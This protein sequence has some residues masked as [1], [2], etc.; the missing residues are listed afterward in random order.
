MQS[1]MTMGA[2]RAG[3]LAI[4][5]LSTTTASAQAT[6]ISFVHAGVGAG[7]LDG[8][9]FSLRDFKIT[10]V[11]DTDDRVPF[12]GSLK[13]PHQA[14]SILIAGLGTFDI[15]T[16]THTSVS[17]SSSTVEYA[18][19]IEGGSALIAGPS[20]PAF[21]TWNMLDAVGPVSGSALLLQWGD[22]FAPIQTSGGVLF[23]EV[24]FSDTTFQA[25]PEPSTFVM[26]GNAGLIMAARRRPRR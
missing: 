6:L 22:P 9:P 1:V 8:E 13:I 7:T 19:S 16:P 26:L 18:R 21:S 3:L 4:A 14:S 5:L 12:F 10:S 24:G 25:I 20:N 11:G 2:L 15:L 23:F 17:N